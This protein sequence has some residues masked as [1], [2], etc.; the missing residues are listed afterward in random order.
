MKKYSEKDMFDALTRDYKAAVLIR[1]SEDPV[2][3]AYEGKMTVRGHIGLQVQAVLSAM[4]NLFGNVAAEYGPE[5][6]RLIA[7]P[8]GRVLSKYGY[9]KEEAQE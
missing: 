2:D 8:F 7:E 5:K 3:G 1:L 4:E 6:A 9:G